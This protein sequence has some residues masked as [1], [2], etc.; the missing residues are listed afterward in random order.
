MFIND[1]EEIVVKIYYRQ[2][3]KM[4]IAH[5][6]TELEELK[7]KN[8]ISDEEVSQLKCITI[9]CPPLTWGLHNE[10][11]EAA[12]ATDETGQKKWNYRAYKENKLLRIIKKWD[13]TMNNGDEKVPAPVNPKVIAKLAPEIAE[14]ILSGYDQQTT[15]G[16][17]EEKK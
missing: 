10:I 11:Q 3:N 12:L 14:A 7:K 8:K 17:E 2:N 4:Y 13:A 15:L 6:E 16:E 5:T 1:Q 9:K